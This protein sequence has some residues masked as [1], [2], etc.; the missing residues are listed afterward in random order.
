VADELQLT[1]LTAEAGK[2]NKALANT[3]QMLNALTPA[4]SK[5]KASFS[6]LSTV[7]SDAR[8][9]M[10][11]AASSGASAIG[12]W[13]RGPAT[14]VAS[15]VWHGAQ[16]FASNNNGQFSP[17]GG[18]MFGNSGGGGRGGGPLTTGIGA[19][20]NGSMGDM[21]L[22]AL[23]GA[24][25]V[26]G[27]VTG[28]GLQ[29][30]YNR[31]QGNRNTTLGIS[32]ALAPNAGMM[33][34]KVQ[35]LLKNL[36]DRT[37][38]KGSIQDIVETV[39]AGQG[40]GAFMTGNKASA[41]SG[42]PGRSGFFESVR[43]MQ[44]LTP[45]IGAG[46]LAGAM[47]N[48][49]GNTQ[50][51]QKGMYL[52][53]GAFTMI[54][55]GG[56]YKSLA[57]W[58]ESILKFLSEQRPGGGQG[59]TFNKEEL[60]AQNFPG[61]NINAWFQMMG[62]PQNMADYWWQYALA[63]AGKASPVAAG[64]LKQGSQLQANVN[65]DRGMDLGYERVRSMAQGSRRDILMGSEMYGMYGARE[66]ADRRFNVGMQGLDQDLAKLAT[67]TNLGAA[68]ALA[69][70][71]L[72]S[73]FMPLLIKLASSKMGTLLSGAGLAADF[74]SG[75]GDPIGDTSPVGDYGAYGGT[76][77]SHLSPDLGKR[78][79][80]M[81]KA[82]PNLKI[83]SGYRD[84]VT[85]NRLQKQGVGR[86]GSAT[87]SKHTR[88]WAADLGPNNQ[89]GWLK[90]NAG[91]FGLQTASYDNEPWHVQLAGTMPYGDPSSG[92]ASSGLPIGGPGEAA[93]GILGGLGG[94]VLATVAAEA[95]QQLLTN[96]L[97]GGSFSTI[98][99]NLMSGFMKLATGPIS[100]LSDIFGKTTIDS[101]TLDN[102]MNQPYS[103]NL[104]T[105][106]AGGKFFS[107]GST[108]SAFGDPASMMNQ[109]PTIN[110][111]ME[112]PIIFKTE[113]HLSSTGNS[114]IDAQRTA[115]TIANHLETE[116]ARREWRK[117]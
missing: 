87:R 55:K 43:Q 63:N 106:G 47:S 79:Q 17:G 96:M 61:S 5:V 77:T 16:V 97:K 41:G 108:D 11:G 95:L 30:S 90:A 116:F 1:Q 23:G 46:Q 69:P 19:T 8:G 38:V 64:L 73:M 101:S 53:Q 82:N 110:A 112:S 65:Q 10:G 111:K 45:G 103:G 3:A 66:S 98:L 88:G 68:M 74:F 83:T 9:A 18:G 81:M 75:I 62:V 57:E 54:G 29:Y 37:P 13:A 33:G 14:N 85:Q 20:A 27:A 84:T 109:S 24:A 22:G 60:M 52:G 71:E 34:M 42:I 117:S 40:V 12:S 48:Y 6:S 70:S 32:Q 100:G 31:F 2:L 7:W 15:S 26:Y 115:S 94:A 28:A 39:L 4:V 93:T 35:D 105:G 67:G 89:L 25:D 49:I 80:A 44:T 58:A 50:S 21:F 86:V 107:S 99:D 92:S 72:M 114:P 78:V 76:S 113:I 59:N 102:L 104:L 51:Q 56:S 91:K 36:G